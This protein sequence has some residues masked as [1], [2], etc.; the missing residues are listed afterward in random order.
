MQDHVRDNVIR[1][2]L[3]KI[4]VGRYKQR[5]SEHLERMSIIRYPNWLGRSNSGD[6]RTLEDQKS[7][8]VLRRNGT[9][10]LS[11]ER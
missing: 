7:A 2:E 10:I 1:E 4:Q 8:G 9:L 6:E 11:R 3:G 5:W